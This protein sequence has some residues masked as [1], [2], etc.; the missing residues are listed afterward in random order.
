MFGLV[1]LSSSLRYKARAKRSRNQ[2]IP[3]YRAAFG[4][5][6]VVGGYHLAAVAGSGTLIGAVARAGTAARKC[7]QLNSSVWASV[8]DVLASV[9]RPLG[10]EK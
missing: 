5:R 1:L 4:L 9:W 7:F 2:N 6:H 10:G 8:W 3:A